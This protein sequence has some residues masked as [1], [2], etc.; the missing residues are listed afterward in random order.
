[1]EKINQNA[2]LRPCDFFDMICGTSTSEW[3]ITSCRLDL[4]ADLLGLLHFAFAVVYQHWQIHQ[5]LLITFRLNFPEGL[6][7]KRLQED[8]LLKTSRTTH[9]KCVM[10]IPY[11][12]KPRQV[13][14]RSEKSG[15]ESDPT[16]VEPKSIEGTIKCLT[17]GQ[18]RYLSLELFQGDIFHIGETLVATA[19]E[20]E[21]MPEKFR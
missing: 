16:N 13:R 6:H 15:V 21:K 10:R 2:P 14:V 11:L 7:K 19:I 12:V 4:H 3:I 18:N 5:R 20:T 9:A 17:L 1:M 8:A